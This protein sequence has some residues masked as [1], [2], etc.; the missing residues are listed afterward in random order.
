M[1]ASWIWNQ[2]MLAGEHIIRDVARAVKKDVI[3]ISELNLYK[4]GDRTL[5]SRGD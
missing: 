4:E 2:G 1:L 5:Y 3:E